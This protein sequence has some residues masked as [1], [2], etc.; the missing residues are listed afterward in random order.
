MLLA[1]L[2]LSGCFLV[3][4][5]MVVYGVAV[6]PYAAAGEAPYCYAFTVE[7]TFGENVLVDATFS[8][9]NFTSRTSFIE[10]RMSKAQRYYAGMPLVV[11]VVCLDEAAAEVGS[12]TYVG[13]LVNPN[14]TSAFSLW[15]HDVATREP[16]ECVAPSVSA[17][18]QLCATATGFEFP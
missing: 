9:D 11:D 17:G 7:A 14:E 2:G 16:G 4:K 6:S 1:A 3:N 12:A 15:T 8:Q 10:P 5:D 18:V 13:T